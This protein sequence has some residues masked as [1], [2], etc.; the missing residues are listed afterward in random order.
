MLANGRKGQPQGMPPAGNPRDEMFA[1][2]RK[3]A[4][5]QK[6]PPRG[7]APMQRMAPGPQ[8]MADGG[9]G[10]PPPIGGD[11]EPDADDTSMLQGGQDDGGAAS[12]QTSP[13]AGQLP[14]IRPEALGYHDDPRSC[15]PGG[16]GGSPGCQYFDNGNCSVLQMSVA[17][18]GGC[19]GFEAL[20]GGDMGAPSDNSGAP[21]S[22][23]GTSDGG[24]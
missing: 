23:T 14:M 3:P 24:M 21:Q 13:G 20:S 5:F 15:T 17:G 22:S 12:A 9:V 7:G 4:P 10:A 18:P 2:G 8:M 16:I 19:A 11:G 6:M 1:N